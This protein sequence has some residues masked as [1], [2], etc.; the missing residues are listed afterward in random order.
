V[1]EAA[2]PPVGDEADPEE[3]GFL[4]RVAIEGRAA[5]VS[6]LC[7]AGR[8]A[9]GRDLAQSTL[10]RDPYSPR[11]HAALGE[12]LAGLGEDARALQAYTN[13][14]RADA[15]D[16]VC[17]RGYAKILVRHG[18]LQEAINAYRRIVGPGTG[19]IKDAV[20]L[21]EV[22]RKVGDAPG[23]QRV[24][25]AVFRR[26]PQSLIPLRQQAEA[27]AGQG[28]LDGAARLLDQILQQESSPY[29]QAQT[30]AESLAPRCGNSAL[31]RLA[32]AQAF[33]RVGR[34]F[35]TVRLL[36]T[37]V[38][39]NPADLA[40]RRVLGLAYARLGAGPQAE[41]QLLGVAKRGQA[42]VEVYQALGEV[43]LERGDTGSGVKALERARDAKPD[44]A[45]LRRSLARARAAL[46]DLDGA[47]RELEEAAKLAGADDETLEDELLRLTERAYSKRVKELEARLVAD[48]TDAAARLDLAAALAQRGDLVEAIEQLQRARTQ[49]GLAD[50]V[51]ARAEQIGE[52]FG[53][54][55]M[56]RPLAVLLVE[57]YQQG[58]KLPKAIAVVE[59]VL[60]EHPEDGEFLLRRVELLLVA[61][62]SLDAASALEALL[63]Q[64]TPFQL[65]AAVGLGARIL[66]LG[67]HDG[68]AQPLARAKRRMGDVEGAARL[69]ERCLQADPSNTD[70]R[71]EYAKLLEGAG[72]RAEAYEVL[73]VLVEDQT[74][75]TAELERLA[76]L[77][78]GAG[79]VDDAVALLVR[80]SSR[81]PEDL[82]LKGALEATQAR[83][84]EA[85][86]ALL[87][88]ATAP[89]E[90]EELAGLYAE[91]G[92]QVEAVRVL[93]ALGKIDADQPELSF[94]RFSAEH[95]AKQG[96]EDKAEA[97]L[98][99]VGRT[100][101][102]APGSEQQKELLLRIATIHER[103]GK[104]AAARRVFLELY[105]A[106]PGYRDVA[107]RLEVLS[108]DVRGTT[109]GAADERVLELVDVGA[110]LGTIFDALKDSDLSLDPKLLAEG[111]A[112]SAALKTQGPGG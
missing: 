70:A 6:L 27:R 49:P 67:G 62:R 104:R 41:E 31:A 59:Q 39:H 92:N 56:P 80:A 18:R 95:F 2:P 83:Q 13:A 52:D 94:L 108:E 28:D 81:H 68:L 20:A 107:A 16:P 8:H 47:I 61:D 19:A 42:D 85:R 65:E 25:D 71:V 72:R 54:G 77:A 17:V 23:A 75:S 36:A 53:D 73:K 43:Y 7:L 82:A 30:L 50:Q 15:N 26:D 3:R 9:A 33:L 21:A 96:K 24:L 29:A 4:S 37:A 79:R 60:A 34:P 45:A 84:R 57:L 91:Q 109:V 88:R 69:F 5:Q 103:A 14:V 86:I 98:R 101:N 112:S 110:P 105:S 1:P 10:V 58:G 63:E 97:A 11:G 90:R 22:L 106:D 40:S 111:K 55:S 51:T 89:A 46:G 12:A 66:E 35:A 93:R 78:L 48:E 64:A 38:A 100:L 99:H 76:T 87:Q 74:G 44:D 102:Y 32:C